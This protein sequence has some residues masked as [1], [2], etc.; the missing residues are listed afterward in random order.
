MDVINNINID[1]EGSES[2][3]HGRKNLY[4]L[5]EYIYHQEQTDAGNMN[6]KGASG[7]DSDGS[8]KHVLETGKRAILIKWCRT[9]PNCIVL[10][11]G[12]K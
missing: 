12:R 9:W 5:R 4:H 10:F 8:E 6:G 7:E 1:D 2:E 11:S 3:K